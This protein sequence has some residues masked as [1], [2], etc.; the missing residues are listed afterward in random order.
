[1]RKSVLGGAALLALALALAACGGK[2]APAPDQPAGQQA[3]QDVSVATAK[4]GLGTVLVDGG[5]RT[6]YAFT[7]DAGGRSNCNGECAA[8]WPRLAAQ[9]DPVAG[10]GVTASLLGTIQAA[11]GTTQVTY[12]GR[13]VYRYGGDAQP[14]DAN[15]QG[16]NGLWFALQADG[17][18]VGAPAGSGGPAGSA[19]GRAAGSATAQL[20][21]TRLGQVLVDAAGRTLYALKK[22]ASG[23]STCN[24]GCAATWPPLTID[25]GNPVPGRGL[26]ASLLGIT[27]RA[28]GAIQVTYN[29]WPLYAY[30]GDR[31]PGDT[32]GQG[33]GGVWYAVGANGKLVTV[34]PAG[35][36]T[37]GTSG[38]YGSGGGYGSSG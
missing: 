26:D 21:S 4:L 5:G 18:L 38:D 32:A 37:A 33:I 14:G 2:Q 25:A 8:T 35:G 19:A 3:K 31:R 30:A 6:L 23:Q 15:G 36:A 13:P 28:N 7:K 20:G 10:K 29:D 1:M 24:G 34:A 17:S 27:P 9:G 12:G 16:L 11:D 22:D